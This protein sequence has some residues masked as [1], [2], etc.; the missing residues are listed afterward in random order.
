M[1]LH[2]RDPDE[3]DAALVEAFLRANPSW[4]A[5]HSDLYRVLTPPKRLHGEPMA[6]HMAAMLRAERLHAAAMATRADGVLAAGRAAAG[7]TQRVQSA[8]LAL[9]HT[10]DP[11][12]C[13]ASEFPGIL[14]IDGAGLCV[15]DHLPG[16]RSL[17]AGAVAAL[18]DG[19]DVVFRTT[20]EDATLLHAEAARL[21]RHDA[22][23]RVP[24]PGAPA[25]LALATRDSRSLDPMQGT[26]ALAF[27]G[28]AV[29]AALGR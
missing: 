26:G 12:D 15:E 2:Q 13:V 3:A 9:I 11:T 29:G 25:L 20:P 7:L 19:R 17:P 23:V 4:L 27:L 1:P 24:W 28:R 10:H 6:D 21:A 22:L 16:T 5:D 18:L 8:V 14:A